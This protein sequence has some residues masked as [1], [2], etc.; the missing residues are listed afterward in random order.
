MS[1]HLGRGS[2]GKLQEILSESSVCVLLLSILSQPFQTELPDRFQHRVPGLAVRLLPNP[3]ETLLDETFEA[4]QRI[5]AIVFHGICRLKRPAAPENA[6]L[7]EESLLIRGEQVVAP[8]DG[9]A[10]GLLAWREING[11]TGQ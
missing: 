9:V 5:N 8:G 3:D 1:E 10:Q 7:A 6:Q 4:V 2:L 11:A